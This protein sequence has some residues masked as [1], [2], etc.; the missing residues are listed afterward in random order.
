[1]GGGGDARPSLPRSGSSALF[2]LHL[3]SYFG[4]TKK[5][6]SLTSGRLLLTWNK[7]K[8]AQPVTVCPTWGASFSLGEGRCSS[9]LLNG[10]T[11]CEAPRVRPERICLAVLYIG[12][13]LHQKAGLCLS[14]GFPS[15]RF[16]VRMSRLRV[17][18]DFVAGDAIFI[19]F[20]GGTA[21]RGTLAVFYMLLCFETGGEKPTCRPKPL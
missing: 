17:G 3:S 18:G 19:C 5:D 6:A 20:G 7:I 14:A 21:A 11:G 1:M 12:F 2:C 10:S 8:S 4:G 13:T 16:T 9:L 15:G